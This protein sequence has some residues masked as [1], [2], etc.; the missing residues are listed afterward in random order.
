M[1]NAFGAIIIACACTFALGQNTAIQVAPVEK[2]EKGIPATAPQLPTNFSMAESASKDPTPSNYILGAE[3]Q[4]TLWA[5]EAE[6]LSGKAVQIDHEGRIN[7]PLIGVVKAAGLTVRQLEQELARQL[8]RFLRKPQVTVNVTEFRS[9]PV[10]VL[11]A[12]NTPGVHQLRGRKSLVEIL[13]M[14]GGLR[15]DA[16]NVVKVTRRSDWGPIPLQSAMAQN[17]SGY[18]VAEIPLASLIEARDPQLNIG[19]KPHDVVSVPKAEMVYVIG[20][21]PRAGGYVMSENRN[22]SVLQAITLAGGFT[23][24]AAPSKARILRIQNTTGPRVELN[25]D[26]SKVLKG[27]VDDLR[28]EANDILY[29]PTSGAKRVALKTIE[30]TVQTATGI[31]VW[32]GS[33]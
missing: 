24:T 17:G 4:L 30:L 12:L 27:K 10:S 18:S 8:G 20:D 19:I 11:G 7:L 1:K 3:D 6:E 5:L 15:P 21:V 29:V 31:A 33:R 26:L 32:R 22:M 9:Q 14:A 16:G 25:V 2:N 13:S 28:L 23:R